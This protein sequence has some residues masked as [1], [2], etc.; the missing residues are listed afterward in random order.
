MDRKEGEKPDDE[1]WYVTEL[2]NKMALTVNGQS[3]FTFA[4][5]ADM[6]VERAL[7]ITHNEEKK[8]FNYIIR[9]NF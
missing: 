3:E 5:K 6:F 2:M 8:I 9:D 7:R 1:P 4:S